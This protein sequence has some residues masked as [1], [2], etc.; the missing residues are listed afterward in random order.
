M[1]KVEEMLYDALA[2]VNEELGIVG[3]HVSLE[4]AAGT[5]PLAEEKDYI[6]SCKGESVPQFRQ[7]AV[8]TI[9][10]GDVRVIYRDFCDISLAA[11]QSV[12]VLESS[13]AYDLLLDVVGVLLRPG[14]NERIH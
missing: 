11:Q 10:P 2:S 1:A 5:L 14:M 12:I 4:I 13:D 6:L 7:Q 8:L 3:L 9:G